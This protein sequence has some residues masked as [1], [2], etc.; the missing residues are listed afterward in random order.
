MPTATPQPMTIEF[1]LRRATRS[2]ATENTKTIDP[3]PAF[4]AGGKN[5]ENSVRSVADNSQVLR[6]ALHAL[7]AMARG[8]MYDVVGGGFSRYS[9]DN[10]WRVPHF[11]N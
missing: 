3:A 9:T 11:D 2:L 8:G 4:G 5:S 6:P 7:R 10:F 1:L